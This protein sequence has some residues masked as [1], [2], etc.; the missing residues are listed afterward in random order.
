[1]DYS[2]ND[3]DKCIYSKYED[4]TYV[5]IYL[6]VDDM[7]I[8]GTSLEVLCETKKFL[9]SKFDMKDLG[10]LEVI[11]GITITRTPNGFKFSQEHYVENILRK[12]EHFDCRLSQYTQ[13]PNQNHWIIV[14]RDLKYLRGTIN[15]DISLRMKPIPSVS[16]HCDS[17]ATIAKAKKVIS[18]EFVR[19]E[20]NLVDPLTKPL[21]K[22]L[23]E[24]TSRRMRLM[25]ITE[26]KSGDRV[27]SALIKV[28]CLLLMNTIF[29]MDVGR[30]SR[31]TQSPNQDHL[32]VVRRVLKYLRGT[33][34]YGLCFS[35]FP[36]VLEGFSDANWILNSDEM[37]STSGYV[38]ILGRSAVSWKYPFYE[39][40]QPRLCLCIVIVKLQL[41]RLR[42]TW[43]ICTNPFC[44]THSEV[45]K[46]NVDKRIGYSLDPDFSF[47]KIVAPYAQRIEEFVKQLESGDLKLRVRVLESSNPHEM[48]STL[49][50][51]G[52]ENSLKEQLGMATMYTVF[53][54]ILLNLGVTLA[55]QGSQVIANESY[56]GAGKLF[57][58][59][60][61]FT[62]EYFFFL[63]LDIFKFAF[64][65]FPVAKISGFVKMQAFS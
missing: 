24:E 7:L 56:V 15:Y 48:N 44:A 13:S 40:D 34:N 18:L 5:V 8:F 3:T 46:T 4:N 63:S 64:I 20:L 1:M 51:F 12:F 27:Y 45:E 37:K 41:L 36:S 25:P 47:E 11:L 10:E 30:L 2:I 16:M 6:Y 42:S 32:T 35:G 62:L 19:S 54:G 43:P 50:W 58:T 53:G 57:L 55:N 26:L 31:Y 39:R 9:G 17:Q 21:N 60:K 28:E 33:I 59:P 65:N 61:T 29:L 52:I 14:R 49:F 22:K 38:F 23:V